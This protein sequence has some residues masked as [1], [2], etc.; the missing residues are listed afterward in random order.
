MQSIAE[1]LESV[2]TIALTGL[3]RETLEQEMNQA[4]E[5]GFGVDELAKILEGTPWR[6]LIK[7]SGTSFTVAHIDDL[8]AALDDS[9]EEF[10]QDLAAL[11]LRDIE[12][13]TVPQLVAQ[14]RIRMRVARSASRHDVGAKRMTRFLLPAE[15]ADTDAVGD[16]DRL[17]E[18]CGFE[19]NGGDLV[20]EI[21]TPAHE[22]RFPISIAEV[23]ARRSKQTKA[24]TDDRELPHVR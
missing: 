3:S 8:R 12:D 5:D 18:E 19:W 20:R 14:T 16:I 9:L 10:K 17:L 24:L 13:P 7:G 21:W 15:A 2:R 23:K 4:L 6:Y 22:E 11:K 1:R